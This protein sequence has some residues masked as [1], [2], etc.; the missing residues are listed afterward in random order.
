MV[1]KARTED[2]EI[3]LV[4]F[5][6]S[7]EEYGV[8]IGKVQEIVNLGKITRMPKAPDFVEGIINLRG[9]VVPIIDIK[10]RFDL[11]TKEHDEKTRI[12]VVLIEGQAMGMIVDSVSEVLRLPKKDIEPPPPIMG[13]ISSDYIKGVGKVGDR[14]VTLL[15][16]DKVLS[17]E[18]MPELKKTISE[19]NG[20]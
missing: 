17:I 12:M 3:Q 6:L 10:K 9:G 15:D 5:Q 4:V 2:T 16:L 19:E 20:A 8:A 11:A 18:V 13:D 1:D 7:D 14:I